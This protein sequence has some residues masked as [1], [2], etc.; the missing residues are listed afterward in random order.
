[1]GAALSF[2]LF[3]VITA[4]NDWVFGFIIFIF[5]AVTAISF[6]RVL[7]SSPFKA[8]PVILKFNLFL[9]AGIAGLCFGF[10]A[11]ASM[12]DTY[13]PLARDRVTGLT[14]ILSDDPR[15][16][17]DG[18]G[19]GSLGLIQATGAGGV[20]TTAKGRI[21]VFFPAESIP[22]IKEFGRGCEIYVEGNLISGERGLVFRA[23]QV[24]ILKPAPA[25]EQFRTGLRTGAL[26]RFGIAEDSLTRPLWSG[27]ASAMLLG[28]RDD[29]DADLA[30]SFR[31]AGSSHVLSLS[32]MHLAILS[33]VIIFLLRLI[34]GIRGSSLMGAV[35][36]VVYIFLAGSQASLV[37][38]GI[39]SLL[40]TLALLGH[41]KKNPLSIL[42]LAFL[43]QLLIQAESG[44]SVSFILSYL[45][46]AGILVTGET[47]REILRGK[48]PDIILLGFSASAGAFIATAG[49]VVYYFGD[50]YPMGLIAGFAIMPLSALFLI[51]AF[52]SLVLISVIPVLFAPLNFLLTQVFRVLEF[53]VA[54]AGRVPGIHTSSFIPV[55]L[56]SVLVAALLEIIKHR[57]RQRRRSIA[58]FDT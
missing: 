18:R 19:M 42:A 51:M 49:A 2:Y 27:L 33:G 50:L 22:R 9:I 14:G 20:R 39:M 24:H 15:A 47:I 44:A 17:N 52:V 32:G 7:V 56:V 23:G 38:A 41:L 31:R 29:L 25:L 3:P 26:E 30:S 37:R 58:S 11:R 40:G 35:F 13:I 57:E 43:I 16:F 53:F 46:L 54:S 55:A 4:N 5:S 28:I 48:L 21:T 45:A 8:A 1:M 10:S 34:F 36:V 12:P 6:L